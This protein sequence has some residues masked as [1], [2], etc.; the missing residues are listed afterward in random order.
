M[1]LLKCLLHIENNKSAAFDDIT[2]HFADQYI[3]LMQ[4]AFTDVNSLIM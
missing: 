2:Q 1:I 4:W 3:N